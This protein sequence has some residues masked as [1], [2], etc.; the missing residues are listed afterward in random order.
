M[1]QFRLD[2]A[3]FGV[4]LAIPRYPWQVL[5]RLSVAGIVVF[6][7]FIDKILPAPLPSEVS[8]SGFSVCFF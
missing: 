3:A 7:L 5:D 6:V 4:A 8:R 1:A 2:S